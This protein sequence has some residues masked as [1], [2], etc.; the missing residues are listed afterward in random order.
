[1][2]GRSPGG[3][4][5]SPCTTASVSPYASHDNP[6]GIRI[7]STVSLPAWETGCRRSSAGRPTVVSHSPSIAASFIGCRSATSFAARSPTN[8]CTGAS[9]SPN[10]SPTASARR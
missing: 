3:T 6:P 1:M 5:F 9:T 4:D 7:P 2:F 8:T 10:V